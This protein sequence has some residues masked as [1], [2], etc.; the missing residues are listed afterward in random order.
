M[1]EVIFST[2]KRIILLFICISIVTASLTIGV[3]KTNP[4][5]Q[6]S[7]STTI[8]VDGVQVTS[9]SGVDPESSGINPARPVFIGFQKL[10]DQGGAKAADVTKLKDMI[11]DYILSNP[12]FPPQTQVSMLDNSYCGLADSEGINTCEFEITIDGQQM[13][14]GFKTD[15]FD[16]FFLAVIDKTGHAIINKQYT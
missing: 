2:K 3:Y 10:S 5:I 13:K 6:S 7:R 4:A 12:R 8:I 9:I 11:I 15:W 14:G 1:F 16:Y